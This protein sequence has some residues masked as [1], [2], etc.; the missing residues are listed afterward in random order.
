[1]F[2][3]RWKNWVMRVTQGLRDH[4][5][6]AQYEGLKVKLKAIPE[7]KP[8]RQSCEEILGLLEPDK[9]VGYQ[10]Y[11]A[12]QVKLSEDIANLEAFT[13]KL[14]DTSAMV[15]KE[16][17][18]P[19]GWMRPDEVVVPFDRLFVATGGYYLDVAGTVHKFKVAGLRLCELM[20]E[21]DTATHGI[22]EHNFR[23]LSRLFVQLRELSTCL[24]EVSLE[25][26]KK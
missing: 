20:K 22:H 21:S 1:M 8:H 10:P 18:I 13:K 4:N 11:Y 23:M 7:K 14:L 24:V 5:T 15:L 6:R 26:Q 16:Q 9:Y 2:V 19:T 25:Q 3:D 17:P 12:K